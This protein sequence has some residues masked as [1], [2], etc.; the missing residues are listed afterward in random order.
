MIQMIRQIQTIQIMF[1]IK[2]K[3][4]HL[5]TPQILQIQIVLTIL[6]I[7]LEV[8]AK[9]MELAITELVMVEVTEVANLGTVTLEIITLD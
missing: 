1:L 6:E 2:E 8:V 5:S 9:K 4:V 3:K 7:I